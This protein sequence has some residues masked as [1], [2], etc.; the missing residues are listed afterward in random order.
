MYLILG[1]W[2]LILAFAVYGFGLP[3]MVATLLPSPVNWDTVTAALAAWI[4]LL[5]PPLVVLWLKKRGASG[6]A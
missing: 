2:A 5:V 1:L 3:G 6:S 4:I